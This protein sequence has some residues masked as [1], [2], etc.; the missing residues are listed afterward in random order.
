MRFALLLPLLLIAA[1]LFA[2]DDHK[3]Q[4]EAAKPIAKKLA[5]K[6]D[7]EV[8]ADPVFS[9]DGSQ[10]AYVSTQPAGYFNVYIRPFAD[11]DWAGEGAAVTEDNDYG[12][13]RLYFGPQDIHLFQSFMLLQRV[14]RQFLDLFQHGKL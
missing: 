12:A 3:E 7:E 2:D 13:N 11:G 8:Y 10:I 5:S 4:R 1:P 14:Q 9:P 6:N